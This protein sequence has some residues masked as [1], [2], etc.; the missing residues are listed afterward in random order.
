MIRIFASEG[1]LH[2]KEH[3]QSTALLRPDSYIPGAAA[4][5][6][7]Q[8]A[9]QF[10]YQTYSHQHYTI[11]KSTFVPARDQTLRAEY[12]TPFLGFRIMLKN[13]I[14]YQLNEK[15]YYLMQGQVNFVFAPSVVSEMQLKKNELYQVF[16]LQIDPSLVTRLKDTHPAVQVLL[17]KMKV[18]ETG[19]LLDGPGFASARVLDAMEDLSRDPGNE[20]LALQLVELVIE[21]RTMKRVQRSISEKQIESLFVVKEQIRGQIAGKQH[22]RDWARAAGM[23]ITYFK[24]LFKTVFAIAPYH[25]LMYERIREAK[26]MMIYYPQLTL[27]EVAEACGFTNYNNLRRAFYAIERITLSRWQKLS[28]I[29]GVLLMLEFFA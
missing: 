24:E 11:F 29:T 23:N 19:A 25:Y 17:E 21:A 20:A 13:H 9:G 7:D 8:P 10:F 16:D 18:N 12:A 6:A 22:L 3:D 5:D 4:F 15:K 27:T 14:R 1:M 28:D 26:R 2:F